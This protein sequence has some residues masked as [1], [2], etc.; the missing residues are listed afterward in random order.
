[1]SLSK[2]DTILLEEYK[3]AVEYVYNESEAFWNRFNI[4]TTLNLGLIAAYNY[5][6]SAS[7][8]NSNRELELGLTMIVITGFINSVFWFF[9]LNRLHGYHVY[10]QTRVR[11]IEEHFKILKLFT[12]VKEYFNK[13]IFLQRIS[14]NILGI[15]L[16]FIFVILWFIILIIRY[17]I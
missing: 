10:W 13:K 6:L 14:S 11:K 7:T 15:M 9:I 8:N 17:D 3:L 12:G 1:M 2:E 5:I 16:S 4:G